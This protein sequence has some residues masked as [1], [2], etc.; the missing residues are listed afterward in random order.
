MKKLIVSLVCIFVMMLLVTSCF[1]HTYS[2][3]K[4]AQTGLEVTK[5]NYYLIYG[6]V[7]VTTSDPTQMSG[8][9]SDYTVTHEWTFV[10]GFIS[11]ITCGI[12]NP[13]TTTVKK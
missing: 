3:G 9:A 5:K 1:T 2:V 4:G 13:T 11:A 6:L 12:L 8:G 7:P 10:D